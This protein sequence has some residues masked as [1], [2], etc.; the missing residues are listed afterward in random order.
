[1]WNIKKPRKI[2]AYSFKL[3]GF[4]RL[5]CLKCLSCYKIGDIKDV[6]EIHRN[7]FIRFTDFTFSTQIDARKAVSLILYYFF[8]LDVVFYGAVATCELTVFYIGARHKLVSGTSKIPKYLWHIP[9]TKSYSKT[10]RHA[11]EAI[12]FHGEILTFTA[13]LQLHHASNT[14]N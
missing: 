8:P 11:I 2:I 9:M 6:K 13:S 3:H 12:G 7:S 4:F 14:H 1:M 10:Q 5:W